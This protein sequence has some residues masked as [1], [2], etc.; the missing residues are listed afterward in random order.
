MVSGGSFFG[1]V[2]PIHRHVGRRLREVRM[3]RGLTQAE[4]GLAVGV[5]TP[6]IQKYEARKDRISA[7]M[8][9]GLP[10]HFRAPIAAFFGGLPDPAAGASRATSHTGA[11]S[12]LSREA[13]AVRR[14]TAR[15]KFARPP[16][17]RP[18]FPLV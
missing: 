7:T 16:G 1:E 8:P 15:D 11:A 9:H 18:K 3:D 13:T 17:R 5:A 6:Q 14:H 4:L 2:D 12:D 10:R